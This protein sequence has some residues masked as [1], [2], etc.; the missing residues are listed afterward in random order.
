LNSTPG[1]RLLFRPPSAGLGSEMLAELTKT[2]SPRVALV[3]D[4]G[5][6]AVVDVQERTVQPAKLA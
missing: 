2:Y 3:A 4:G 5:E 1:E 6:Y